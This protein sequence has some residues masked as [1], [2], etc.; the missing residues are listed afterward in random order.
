MSTTTRRKATLPREIADRV[1]EFLKEGDL[2]GIVT[3]FHPDC[4]V[5]FPVDE[6]PKKGRAAVREIFAPFAEVR[7]TLISK[8]TGEQI[9]GDTAL[10]QAEWR[11][12]GPDGSLL[13][14]GK[15]TE[16]AKQHEDGSW[17][18]FIDC[19]LGPP[20]PASP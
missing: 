1:A 20:P 7:P 18:Y 15:S 2:E 16:V 4:T 8:I 19:P 12:E 13:A 11:F 3:M 17:M 6:P 9:N 5:C 14:E 10:L